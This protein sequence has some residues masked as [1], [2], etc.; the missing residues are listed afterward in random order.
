[1]DFPSDARAVA[2]W[3]ARGRGAPSVSRQALDDPQSCAAR[4]RVSRHLD[5][6]RAERTA[7][8]QP[9]LGAPPALATRGAGWTETVGGPAPEG[10]L[11]PPVLQRMVGEHGEAASRP[12]AA[13]ALGE[14]ALEPGELVVDRDADRLEGP[15]GGVE[16]RTPATEAA[17]DPSELGGRRERSRAHD[18][19]RHP[20]RAGLLPVVGDQAGEVALGPG[21]HDLGGRERSGRVHAHVQRTLGLETEPTRGVVQLERAH[22]EVEEHAVRSV[23]AEV[24]ENLRQVSEVRLPEDDRVETAGAPASARVRWRPMLTLRLDSQPQL[25]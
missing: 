6:G 21:V 2:G 25:I 5:G 11:H 12:K 14:E 1:W 19:A 7:R 3:S 13:P 9:D 8:Q 17:H 23:A 15:G 20:P 4:P 18:R 22:P 10:V 16:A 24:P